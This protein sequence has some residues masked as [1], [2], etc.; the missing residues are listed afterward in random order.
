[1]HF[2]IL[3]TRKARASICLARAFHLIIRQAFKYF[4]SVARTAPG[5]ATS[6]AK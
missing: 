6:S 4:L 3:F 2:V 1:M 5:P